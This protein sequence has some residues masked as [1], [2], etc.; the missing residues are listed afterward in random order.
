MADIRDDLHDALSDPDPVRRA[1][2]QMHSRCRSVF[3]RL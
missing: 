1:Q 3:I 2:I